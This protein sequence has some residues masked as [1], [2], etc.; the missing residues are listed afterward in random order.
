MEE[1]KTEMRKVTLTLAEGVKKRPA[2]YIG[3]LDNR[4]VWWG[5]FDLFQDFLVELRAASIRTEFIGPVEGRFVL[6]LEK[7]LGTEFWQ[8]LEQWPETGPYDK[9]PF[10]VLVFLCLCG[11]FDIHYLDEKGE[12]RGVHR[13]ESGVKTTAPISFPEEEIRIIE[14]DFKLDR[15]I[16][17]EELSF[18]VDF[19][20]SHI[21]EYA[22]LNRRQHFE[23]WHLQ[24]EELKKYN[25]QNDNGLQDMLENTKTT[26]G[27][28]HIFAFAFEETLGEIGIEIAFAFPETEGGKPF[29]KSFVNSRETTEH[30]SHVMALCKGL[31]EGIKRYLRKRSLIK[32]YRVSRSIVQDQVVA[33]I[34]LRIEHP[35]Y[36]GCARWKLNN[37]EVIPPIS[38]FVRDTI[39]KMLETDAENREK[40]L[41]RF[42]K[43]KGTGKEDKLSQNSASTSPPLHKRFAE[44]NR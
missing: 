36:A 30:G 37:P 41:Y 26:T 9:G 34:N 16:W 25:F 14:M 43:I 28:H 5:M 4:G 29:L 32:H 15:E 17:G 39:K 1:Q 27:N 21:E 3:S 10:G 31:S 7:P 35:V 42:Q 44:P 2:M 22:L 11:R 33:A 23:V 19:L 38:E 12:G 40:L 6:E 24:G 8:V 18:D 20:K 13:F